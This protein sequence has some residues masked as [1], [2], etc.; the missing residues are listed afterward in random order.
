[1]NQAATNGLGWLAIFRLGLVQASIGAIVVLATSTMNRVMVVEL[2]MPAMLPGFLV[3]LHYVVQVLR[4]RL[5]YSSDVGGR[6]TPWIVAGMALLGLATSVAAVAIQW[7]EQAP[8]FG[9]ALAIVAFIFIG[10]GV[11]MVGTSLLV[12]M[13]THI[14]ERRRAAG[15]T[16]TWIMMIFGFVVTS[17]IAGKAL[18]PFST[19]RLVEVTVGISIG[20]TLLTW[21]AVWGVEGRG[22]G[23]RA[24]AVPDAPTPFREALQQVW[25]EGHSRRLTLFIFVA[26]VAYSAQDLILEP[27]AGL[28]FE[29]TP[30]QSTKLSGV[31][32]TGVLIGMALIAI[33]C[34]R[35]GRSAEK[36]RAWTIGGC[37]ASGLSLVTLAIAGFVGI[38]WPIQA[39]VFVLGLSNGVF[40]VGALGSMMNMVGA[41]RRSREGVRMG[42][43]GAAQALAFA[44]GGLGA[45]MLVDFSRWAF[46][47]IPFAYGL[48]FVLEGTLFFIASRLAASAR[49]REEDTASDSYAAAAAGR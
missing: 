17:I 2:A 44:I 26:M 41:G 46:D 38:G 32:N 36:L 4:P 7:M 1:M 18:E 15:A 14:E 28:V 43:W 10:V 6:R 24:D 8:L 25:R 39:S 33:A 22:G 16:L 20:A 27:F 35:A 29:M 31:Q 48:V 45:T 30:A 12:L 9:I 19:A 42:L 21:L 5:G 11:G 13:A 49:L 3:A 40:A 34:T 47:S 23:L 37:V